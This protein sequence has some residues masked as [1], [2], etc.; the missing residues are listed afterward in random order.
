MPVN[1]QQHYQ[2]IGHFCSIQQKFSDQNQTS[3][4]N[5]HKKRNLPKKQEANNIIILDI[6]NYTKSQI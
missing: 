6:T 4:S 1:A 5:V 3:A 2:A